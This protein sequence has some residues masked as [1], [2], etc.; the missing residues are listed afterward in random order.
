MIY[1]FNGSGKE[2]KR[3]ESFFKFKKREQEKEQT[4]T[5]ERIKMKSMMSVKMNLVKQ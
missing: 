4:N 2:N 5:N 1:A 3:V